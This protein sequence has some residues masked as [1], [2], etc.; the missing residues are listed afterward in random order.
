VDAGRPVIVKEV[1]DLSPPR[2]RYLTAPGFSTPIGG[3]CKT[4]PYA[5]PLQAA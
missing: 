1:A 3:A 2:E 4:K 5:R